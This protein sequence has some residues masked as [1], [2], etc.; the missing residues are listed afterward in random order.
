MK[1]KI[2]SAA[3]IA[4]IVLAS[5]G[6]SS[7]KDYVDKSIIPAGTDSL[8]STSVT[9]GALVP[10]ANIVSGNAPVIPGA[11]TPVSIG[12]TGQPISLSQNNMVT[13]VPQTAGQPVAPGMNPPH[14]EP[15]HR[16]DISVGAPLNSKPAPAAQPAAA[17]PSA[18]TMTEVP[19]KVNTAPGM[20]PPHGEPG[21][22]CDIAVGAAL[23]SKPP[24][25]ASV[26]ST[27]PPPA[28]NNAAQDA[29][30]AKTAITATPPT[31]QKTAPG[32]N[33]PHG[34]PGHR[35]DIEVGKPL[36]SKPAAAVKEATPPPLLTPAKSG[37]K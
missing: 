28:A 21:H 29:A 22:R 25:P 33:P 30:P 27:T 2:F 31:V 20:N 36:D 6:G 10:G 12:T 5:C 1:F 4:L 18:V 34:E 32:M 35:C 24:L 7:D 9:P 16:C 37:G 8:N 26:V 3:A 11:T 14:G 19:T 15:G 23:N 17:A 13:T